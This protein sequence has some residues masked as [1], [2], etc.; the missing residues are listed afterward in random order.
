[1][2]EKQ[3]DADPGRM[4]AEGGFDTPD[5]EYSKPVADMTEDLMADNHNA[6]ESDGEAD[7][8]RPEIA[9]L[10]TG[11]TAEVREHHTRAAARERII[12]NLHAELERLR[13]G[14]RNLLLRPVVTDLQN[15]RKDLLQHVRKLP[16][17][18]GRD[19]VAG[20]LESYAL[21]VELALERCGSVPIQPTAGEPFSAREH[22]AIKVIRTGLPAQ[23][24][25]VAEVTADG[26]RDTETGRVTTPA[27][28]H[29]YRLEDAADPQQEQE[30]ADA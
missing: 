14:E 28:V 21:S 12:D 16:G 1:M 20:L 26:Y 9:D 10:V 5:A 29:I 3:Q 24:G 22:R 7:G 25:T 4:P 11:L 6:A 8:D 13:A 17:E 18:M 27:R 15:L 19:Q 23:D 30:S 2:H